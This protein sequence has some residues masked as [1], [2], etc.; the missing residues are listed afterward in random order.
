MGSALAIA[1]LLYFQFNFRKTS[2]TVIKT[3]PSQRI[4]LISKREPT[5]TKQ[6]Q[7]AKPVEQTFPEFL[8]ATAEKI[9]KDF[10][11]LDLN[12]LARRAAQLPEDEFI[13]EI[14]S[15]LQEDFQR[16]QR[17]VRAEQKR[18]LEEDGMDPSFFD[19]RV[20]TQLP[21]DLQTRLDELE[22]L[23]L[24]PA[25]LDFV[26]DV[27]AGTRINDDDI[28]RLL[29]KCHYEKDCIEKA[30]VTWLDAHHLLTDFQ[31]AKIENI[32]QESAEG[33]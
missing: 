21:P 11:Q 24:S 12:E 33:P 26:E 9:E 6:A 22:Q 5:S 14:P 1:G 17:E 19:Q 4:A 3:T 8:K 20:D 25:V 16:I 31:L 23:E 27:K 15:A 18:I 7:N 30:V 13:A 29:E 10:P 2:E 28:D 32:I